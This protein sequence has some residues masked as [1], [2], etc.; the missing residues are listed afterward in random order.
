MA[1]IGRNGL[2]LIAGLML[3]GCGD[4]GLNPFGWFSRPAG[5]ETL[6]DIEIARSIDNRPLIVQVA[7]VRAERLPGGVILRATALPPTQGWYSAALVSDGEAENGVL[8][9]ALRAYPPLSPQ[10]SST[11]QSRRID[12]GAYISDA[13]LAG[14]TTL[15]VRAGRNAISVRR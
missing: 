11:V 7:E 12:V 4:S 3:A 13:S 6:E 15:R 10:P 9:F 8:S 1:H 14:V 2:L 5:P